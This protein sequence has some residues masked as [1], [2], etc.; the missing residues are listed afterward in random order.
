ML[1]NQGCEIKPC[2][3]C[4]GKARIVGNT[5]RDYAPEKWVQCTVCGVE[6]VLCAS[7]AGAL[8]KWNRRAEPQEQKECGVECQC[9]CHREPEAAK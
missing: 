6:T 5:A 4:S 3:F 1:I 9:S 8:E 7:A 2:P